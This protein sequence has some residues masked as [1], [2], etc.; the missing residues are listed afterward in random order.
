[1]KSLM[2]QCEKIIVG[3]TT[4][5]IITGLVA[6]TVQ[7]GII[8]STQSE[9]GANGFGGWNL[10]NVKVVLNDSNDTFNPETG[11]YQFYENTDYTYESIVY[12]TADAPVFSGTPMGIVLAK[13]WPVGEPSGIKIVNNDLGVKDPKPQNCIMAT[14]YLADH[15]LDSADPQ[16][17]TCSSPFQTHKRYKL[18]M[19]PSTV[20]GIGSESVDLVFNVEDEDG[21]RDYQVFQKINNWTDGRLEGFTIQ[22]GFGIGENFQSTTEAAIAAGADDDGVNEALDNLHLTVPQAIWAK[23]QLANFSEGLFGPFDDKTETLGFFDPAQRAGFLINEYVE[24]TDLP[25]AITDTLTATQT[26]GSDYNQIPPETGPVSQFGP[27]LPSSML[28]YGVFFDDD[29]NPETDAELLAWY[30]WNPEVGGLGWMSGSQGSEDNNAAFSAISAEKILDMGE[31]LSYTMGEIDDLVNVG[32]NYIVTVGDITTFPVSAENTFTIRITPTKDTSGES[33]QPLADPAYVGEDP[34]PW[35]LF[36]SSDAEVLLEP[37]D[38]FVIGSLLT[39][40]VGDADLNQDSESAETVNVNISALGLETISLELTEQGENRGVFAAT[41]PEEFSNVPVGTVVTMSYVEI[42]VDADTGVEVFEIKTSSTKAI[43]ETLPIL[44]DVSITDFSVPES[45]FDG[46][47]RTLKVSIMNDKEAKA[48]A[49]GSVMLTGTD[50]SVFTGEFTDLKV[51]GKLKF[52]FRW[53]AALEPPEVSDTVSWS[54]IVTVN[55]EE[56][57]SAIGSTLVEV[58]RGKNSKQ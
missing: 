35:L 22:V 44:S 30:G 25:P 15:F 10:N 58:K 32:L 52:S 38:E 56:V 1:M 51:N 57:N 8:T 50:G 20:D 46:L 49:S 5:F 13:D 28:P 21:S 3:I 11:D 18:A 48:P 2:N 4:V 17:V 41:L 9:S 33:G 24:D 43:L 14:S 12:D 7:A 31:N 37:V 26:L 36:R 27:W 34:I 23:T 6:T 29:G 47:S 55:N 45:I 40:R 54:V 42:E 16:Q 19:K 39:A 53:T